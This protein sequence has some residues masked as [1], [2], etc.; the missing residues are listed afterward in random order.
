MDKKRDQQ[1]RPRRRKQY[2]VRM[3]AAD[4]CSN[5][6]KPISHNHVYCSDTCGSYMRVKHYRQR[7]EAALRAEIL[8]I[9][10]HVPA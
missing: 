10:G 4:G 5:K 6:F 9:G 2:P 7:Q 3:C 8:K 1:S